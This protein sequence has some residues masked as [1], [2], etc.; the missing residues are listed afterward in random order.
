MPAEEQG[1]VA[2]DGTE[3]EQET[4]R[5]GQSE[6]PGLAVPGH[7]EPVEAELMGYGGHRALPRFG[8]DVR[9]R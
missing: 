3:E 6:E 5:H 2:E 1:G 8:E 9:S 7:V 4:D